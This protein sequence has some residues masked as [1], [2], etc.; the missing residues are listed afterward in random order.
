LGLALATALW[1]A[2][3]T[4]NSEA[5]AS[6]ARAAAILGQDQLAQ[7]IR[8]DGRR[9]D[10]QV[11]V[12]LRKGGWLVSPIL[13]GVRRF[14][15]ARVRVLGFDP[16][17]SPSQAQ[18]Q[19]LSERGALRDFIS[20]P[21]LVYAAPQTAE[22][23]RGYVSQRLRDKADLPLGLVITD[24]AQAQVLLEAPG[25]ISRL[26]LWPDQPL[27]RRS[28]KDLAPELH[29]IEPS[30]VNGLAQLTDSFHL[31]LTAFGFL[32]F[33]VGLF[34]V[35]STIGLAFE[36]RRP[37]FRTLRAVGLPARSLM[38]LLLGELLLFAILAGL[39][40]VGLGYLIAAAL[41]PDVA[42]TLR[43][44][45]GANVEGSV[46]LRGSSVA[47]GI[48][49]AFIGT[50]VA[51][52]QGLWKV[53]SLPLLASAQPQAWLRASE[54]VLR[55]Q[56]ATAVVLFIAAV[57]ISLFGSGLFWGFMLLAALFLASA[58]ILPWLLTVFLR[59]GQRLARG[60]LSEWFWADTRQQLSGLSLSLTALLLALAANVGVGTMVSSFRQTFVDWLDQ[61]LA[62]ELYVTARSEKESSAIR[63]WL[64]SRADAVLPIWSAEVQIAGAP[65]TIYG[66][67]DHVTYRKNWPLLSAENGAW[68][69]VARGE[70][71]LINEQLARR[72]KHSLGEMIS[73]PG[74]WQ[75]RIV[76]I[77]SDYGNPL[78]Q[79]MV[80]IEQLLDRYPD[81]PRLRYAIRVDP[82]KAPAL[83]AELR[84]AF[85]LPEENLI[86]QA[87]I[88]ALSLNTFERT[89]AVT[90][91]LNV[92][93]LGIA[94]MAIFASL[95]TLSSMRLTQVAPVWAIGVTKLD[96]AMM[97]VGRSILLAALTSVVA[98]PLGIGLAW[99][100]LAVVNVEAFGWRLPM[101]L[102]P[103]E[104]LR[105]G[106]LALL[107]GA[108]AAALPALRLE[109]LSPAQFLKVFADER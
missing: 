36:Q 10:Q 34:I 49:I 99:V 29:Q 39:L 40:G 65:A 56:I 38:V 15:D 70:G 102:F 53:W 73:L 106:C 85:D 107:A 96:L 88:K 35:H 84:N 109:R 104:W 26:V 94:G 57:G 74:G 12:T 98:L 58:L 44:L 86:D 19:H 50:I 95:L 6:Y 8:E 28:L 66:F 71:V 41:L 78:G 4:I 46:A 108:L 42:A 27:G 67:A 87:A 3:Q 25:Q 81:A 76:G 9:I 7:L 93:T 45:Y 5:R 23:L 68:D 43:G 80:A 89:F 13:E 105:L 83:A 103:V 24:I 32:S 1:S 18:M 62:S 101:Y 14:G 64:A 79:V 31:N 37:V 47:Q 82:A 21:G 54:R 63:T 72:H 97:E 22:M 17:T 16:L 33:A 61:R 52:G 100:L 55:F 11:F 30:G 90:A 2:V 75:T 48:A 69:Q 20:G 91:A 51:A 59:F 77:Y 60:P 92:L